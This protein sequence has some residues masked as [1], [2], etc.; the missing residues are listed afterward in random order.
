MGRNLRRRGELLHS[1]VEGGGGG[2]LWE[3]VARS[4]SRRAIRAMPLL[5]LLLVDSVRVLLLL[6]LRMRDLF[7]FE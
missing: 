2:L 4:V 6:L 1:E 7:C 3:E 5:L